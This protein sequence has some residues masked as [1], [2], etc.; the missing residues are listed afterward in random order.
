M[1]PVLPGSLKRSRC[2]QLV[3][4]DDIGVAAAAIVQ[5]PSTWIDTAVDV[6][7]DSL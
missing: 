6:A 7:G 3:A 5:D 4:T 1:F 2:L